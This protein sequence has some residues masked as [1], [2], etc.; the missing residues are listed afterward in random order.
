MLL[1]FQAIQQNL[2]WLTQ[3]TTSA[4]YADYYYVTPL[5]INNDFIETLLAAPFQTLTWTFGC[6]SFVGTIE[7]ALISH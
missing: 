7:G 6:P 2:K 3:H 5:K 4:A 1:L